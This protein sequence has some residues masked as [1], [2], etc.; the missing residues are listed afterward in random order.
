MYIIFILAFL[1]NNLG[2]VSIFKT[3]K[4]TITPKVFHRLQRNLGHEVILPTRLTTHNFEKKKPLKFQLPWKRAFS[5]LKTMVKLFR[6][7]ISKTNRAAAPKLGK[8]TD[9]HN[10]F[11]KW[12]ISHIGGFS[13]ARGRHF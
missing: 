2:D 1:D 3:P 7:D 5:P 8:L 12:V 13:R 11:Q 6:C 10:S 4:N 9:S